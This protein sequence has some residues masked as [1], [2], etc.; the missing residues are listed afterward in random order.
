MASSAASPVVLNGLITQGG[1]TKVSLHNPNTGDI[2]WV[3]VG[4]KFGSYTVGFQPGVPGQTA[5]AVVLTLP[6]VREN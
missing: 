6:P 5:D 3:Q 4:K 2:K 1:V